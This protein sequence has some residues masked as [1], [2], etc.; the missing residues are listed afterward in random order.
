MPWL[1]IPDGDVTIFNEGSGALNH[2]S[3]TFSAAN[4]YAN[5]LAAGDVFT[6]P[7]GT[8]NH[9]LINLPAGYTYTGNVRL[10]I[11]FAD[12]AD[13]PYTHTV[14]TQTASGA[15]IPEGT[16]VTDIGPLVAGTDIYCVAGYDDGPGGNGTYEFTLEFEY[17]AA[18]PAEF[19]TDFRGCEERL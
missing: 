13:S 10:T 19:W 1:T 11:T 5:S 12:M 15:T 2:S 17:T 16:Y 6:E 3:G 14:F 8:R 7:S 9:F 4:T 18:A